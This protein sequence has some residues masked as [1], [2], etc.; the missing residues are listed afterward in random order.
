MEDN[1]YQKLD[2]LFDELMLA[3][4]KEGIKILDRIKEMYNEPKK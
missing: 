4:K 3:M 1:K 2:K